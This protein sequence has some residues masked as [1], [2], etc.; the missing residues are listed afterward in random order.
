[1]RILLG[2]A[3]TVCGDAHTAGIPAQRP[4]HDE[5]DVPHACW[6]VQPRGGRL[7]R[8]EPR[9]DSERGRGARRG[10]RGHQGTLQ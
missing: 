10:R 6:P 2:A 3:A 5:P 8:R 1:M 4:H 9:Q 7:P